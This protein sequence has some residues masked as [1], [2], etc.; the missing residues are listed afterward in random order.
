MDNSGWKST[1]EG[2]GETGSA[3]KSWSVNFSNLQVFSDDQEWLW[4]EMK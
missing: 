4:N 3:M 2:P 1:Q